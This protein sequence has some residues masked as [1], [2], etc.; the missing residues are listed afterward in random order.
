MKAIIIVGNTG[1][2][3]STAALKTL[4]KAQ[5]ENRRLY[6][7]DPNND[8]QKYYSEKF[9]DEEAFLEKVENVSNAFIL[10]EEA[11]IFFSNKGSSKKLTSLLVRKDTKIILLFCFSIPFGLFLPMFSN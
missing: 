6:I 3:K 10:F 5:Q 8:Y 7:Y 4:F 9:V 11:T 2:G 1:R